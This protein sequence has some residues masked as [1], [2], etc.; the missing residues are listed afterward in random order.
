[1][2]VHAII[3]QAIYFTMLHIPTAISVVVE[4]LAGCGLLPAPFTA[5]MVTSTSLFSSIPKRLKVRLEPSILVMVPPCTGRTQPLM[6][7]W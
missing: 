6:M 7:K 5:V 2:C 4:I 3:P 1:M